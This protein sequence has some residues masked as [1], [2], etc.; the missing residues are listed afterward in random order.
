MKAANC[1]P[2]ELVQ[3]DR[4]TWGGIIS[5]GRKLLTGRKIG[6]AMIAH[7]LKGC[8]TQKNNIFQLTENIR[9]HTNT[10]VDGFELFSLRS[11]THKNVFKHSQLAS[12][13]QIDILRGAILMTS[14]LSNY[15]I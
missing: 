14:K 2:N 1:V 12:S 10:N 15:M 13:T 5:K 8:D 11:I 6:R 7:I 4:K 9:L 3:K